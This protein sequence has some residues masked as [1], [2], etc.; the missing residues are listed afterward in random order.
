VARHPECQATDM[1]PAIRCL[2]NAV[3]VKKYCNSSMVL[4]PQLYDMLV[5]E[6]RGLVKNEDTRIWVSVVHNHGRPNCIW[7]YNTRITYKDVT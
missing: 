3:K 1:N 7:L 6:V 2:I 5:E 4:D